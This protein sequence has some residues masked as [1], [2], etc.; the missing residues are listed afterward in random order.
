VPRNQTPTTQATAD[1]ERERS[2]QATAWFTVLMGARR[3]EDLQEAAEAQRQLE[4]LGVVVRFGP[5][6][7]VR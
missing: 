2:I 5:K 4:H 6:A 3:D 7:V 1:P